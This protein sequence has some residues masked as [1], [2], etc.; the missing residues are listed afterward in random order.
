MGAAFE[1]LLFLVPMVHPTD[2]VKV[3]EFSAAQKGEAETE[4]QQTTG[5]SYQTTKKLNSG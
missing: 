3:E 2:Q 1:L 4:D 5:C